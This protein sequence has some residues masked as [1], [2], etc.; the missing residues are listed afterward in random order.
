M[1]IAEYKQ[2]STNIIFENIS[3]PA[4]YDEIGELVREA[5]E[6]TTEKQVPVMGTVYRDATPEEE[7]EFERMKDEMPEPE[8]TTEERLDQVESVSDMAYINSE[9]ALAML[10][11]MEV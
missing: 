6:E 1:R 7:A 4:E 8:M 11:E 2:V 5:W 3:H 10:E 9:L